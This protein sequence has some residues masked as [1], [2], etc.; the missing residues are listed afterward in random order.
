MDD[1][2]E[3]HNQQINDNNEGMANT[4]AAVALILIFVS[5]CI[6]WIAGQ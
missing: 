3:L 4:L 1:N 2:I 5:A 6:F